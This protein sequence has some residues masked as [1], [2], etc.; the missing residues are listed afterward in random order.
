MRQRGWLAPVAFQV[1][2]AHRLSRYL[3]PPDHNPHHRGTATHNVFKSVAVCMLS[4]VLSVVSL[5]FLLEPASLPAARVLDLFET[6]CS[7]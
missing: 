6:Y 7:S 3:A 4:F 5:F 1:F 2:P